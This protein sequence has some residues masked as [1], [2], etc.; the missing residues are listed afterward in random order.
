[1]RHWNDHQRQERSRAQLER[2]ARFNQGLSFARGGDREAAVRAYDRFLARFP[3]D[4]RAPE[5]HFQVAVLQEEAGN[6]EDAV[7]HYTAVRAA[8]AP[9]TPTTP[10]QGESVYRAGRLLQT[11]RRY[12]DAIATLRLAHA[13]R[14][15]DDEFRLAALAELARLVEP[16]EPLRALD[17]YRELAEHST[18]PAWRAV[19][20]ERLAV[21]ESESAVAAAAR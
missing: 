18:R 10:L 20:L 2:L 11:L 1:L 4:S 9:G 6:L 8:A 13:L 15:S 12:D 16:R 14:P 5:A 17:I 19:A 7:L 3:Q 21:L